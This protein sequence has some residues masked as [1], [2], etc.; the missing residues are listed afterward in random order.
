M[1]RGQR[2]EMGR[3]MKTK[4]QNA[5]K[6]LGTNGVRRKGNSWIRVGGEAGGV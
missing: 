6:T 4:E 2:W 1:I 3:M 5:L